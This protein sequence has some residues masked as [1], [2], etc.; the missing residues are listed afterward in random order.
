[1]LYCA[2]FF[3]AYKFPVSSITIC[4]QTWCRTF[5]KIWRI[6]PN[7]PDTIAS[8]ARNSHKFLVQVSCACVTEI[9]RCSYSTLKTGGGDGGGSWANISRSS[10]RRYLAVGRTG[11]SKETSSDCIGHLR[12]VRELSP[13]HIA[14]LST[15]W[16]TRSCSEVLNDTGEIWSWFTYTSRS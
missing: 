1:M 3:P 12:A 8:D 14:V 15:A 6:A 9:R 16:P 7:C 10:S 5:I 13:P 2:N 4:T 11:G